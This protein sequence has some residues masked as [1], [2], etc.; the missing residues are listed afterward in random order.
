MLDEKKIK[1]LLLTLNPEDCAK[2]A[3]LIVK[4]E[5]TNPKRE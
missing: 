1:R 5:F 4:D 3:K 2:A